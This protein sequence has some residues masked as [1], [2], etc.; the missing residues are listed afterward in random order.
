MTDEI[1]ALLA[2]PGPGSHRITIDL[3]GARVE[4]LADLPPLRDRLLFVGLNPSPVSVAAGHYFQGRLGRTLWRRLITAQILP[5][6]TDID[7][8]DDALVAAGHGLTDLHRRPSPRDDA[9]DSTLRAGVGPLWHKISVWRPAAVVF[10]WKRAAE[11]AAG[12]RLDEPWG[13]LHGVALSGRPCFLMPG[14]YAP[15]AEVDAGLNLIRNLG[16][17]LPR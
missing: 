1:E 17:S 3:D 6:Q 9:T 15:T 12:R 4:T 2:R 14:P 8:A 5:P 10:V 13:Q 11:I 7:T 16:A